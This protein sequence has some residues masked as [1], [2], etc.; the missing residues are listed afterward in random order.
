[1]KITINLEPGYAILE[2]GKTWTCSSCSKDEIAAILAVLGCIH[3]PLRECVIRITL[4]EESTTGLEIRRL[5]N[6]AAPAA[7]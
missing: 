2:D 1:M 4:P 6:K 7:A 5:L 3:W